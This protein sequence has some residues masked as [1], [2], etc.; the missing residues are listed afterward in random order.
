M[1]GGRTDN[2]ADSSGQVFVA[3]AEGRGMDRDRL[4]YMYVVGIALCTI[5]LGSAATAG[6]YL[7]AGTFGVVIAYL[8]VRYWMVATGKF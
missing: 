5:A 6:D 8:G 4:R 2:R 3:S 7:I 1:E